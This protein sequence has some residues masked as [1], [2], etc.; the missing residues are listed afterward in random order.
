M[1]K[2]MSKATGSKVSIDKNSSFARFA[3]FREN[4]ISQW[5]DS[6]HR[7]RAGT[8][9]RQKEQSFWFTGYLVTGLEIISVDSPD[10]MTGQIHLARSLL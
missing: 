7:S 8:P 3:L 10:T 9:I 2:R 4:N 1:T 5:T 6:I